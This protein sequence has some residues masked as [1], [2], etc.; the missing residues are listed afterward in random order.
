[1]LTYSLRLTKT[2][3][4]Y[5]LRL[6]NFLQ[7][8]SNNMTR[9]KK[10]ILFRITSVRKPGFL[11]KIQRFEASNHSLKKVKNATK[12]LLKSRMPLMLVDLIYL[13]L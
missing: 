5:L 12:S 3:L 2:L 8:F 10:F 6:R 4:T 11:K 9:K 13:D 1:M 7:A